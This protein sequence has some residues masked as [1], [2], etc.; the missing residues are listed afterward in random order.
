VVQ[1]RLEQQLGDDLEV[2]LRYSSCTLEGMLLRIPSGGIGGGGGRGGSSGSGDSGSGKRGRN[3]SGSGRVGRTGCR[4]TVVAVRRAIAPLTSSFSST[5]SSSVVSRGSSGD[6]SS[7]GASRF[8]D[9]DDDDSA[10]SNAEEER[11]R[12]DIN[13]FEREAEDVDVGERIAAASAAAK[14]KAGK[15]AVL[16]E[17]FQLRHRHRNELHKEEE[18]EEEEAPPSLYTSSF[19]LSSDLSCGGGSSGSTASV[20]AD[21][22]SE[23]NVPHLLG[24]SDSDDDPSETGAAEAEAEAEAA[25]AA[26]HD[27]VGQVLHAHLQPPPPPAAAETPVP[28]PPPPAAATA[29]T[30]TATYEEFDGIYHTPDVSLEEE[31]EVQDRTNNNAP[32]TVSTRVEGVGDHQEPAPS[33]A[34][35]KDT[36]KDTD[37]DMAGIARIKAAASAVRELPSGHHGGMRSC[38]RIP[39]ARKEKSPVAVVRS[40]FYSV[41]GDIVDDGDIGD[42]PSLAS[43]NTSLHVS[44]TG[45]CATAAD[46][47][48]TS[49]GDDPRPLSPCSMQSAFDITVTEVEDLPFD[50]GCRL[51]AEEDENAHEEEEE[52]PFD[53]CPGLNNNISTTREGGQCEVEEQRS[54]SPLSHPYP[55]RH[56]RHPQPSGEARHNRDLSAMSELNYSLPDN[57]HIID[58]DPAMLD[59][60][61]L[62][63][64][65]ATEAD[66]TF[67]ESLSYTR[68][69]KSGGRVSPETNATG[70][71]GLNSGGRKSPPS[72][73]M[74]DAEE[75]EPSI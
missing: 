29:T 23:V 61:M 37:T 62:S 30:R 34:A 40:P 64:T 27:E 22:A 21:T 49:P 28:P 18:E 70:D 20:P 36:D 13:T 74:S 16:R 57:D 2:D 66:P 48:E 1:Q 69:T 73:F 9:D 44:S 60:S 17:R 41:D 33:A 26:P 54:I 10:S 31:E 72:C 55:N 63:A 56:K 24:G 75:D 47:Q 39:S 32:A 35:D 58:F 6:V 4:R 65:T 12:D 46:T 14:A 68:D 67:M 53:E 42:L 11:I 25:A 59:K 3:G 19:S 43:P 50:E 15:D 38:C 52:L 71:I 51:I 8:D 7:L 45:T 5:S